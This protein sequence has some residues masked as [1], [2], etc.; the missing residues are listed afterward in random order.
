VPTEFLLRPD[1]PLVGPNYNNGFNMLKFDGSTL[2]SATAFRYVVDL[3]ADGVVG[4]FQK[5]ILPIL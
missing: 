1:Y 4:T 3:A 2:T 5:S